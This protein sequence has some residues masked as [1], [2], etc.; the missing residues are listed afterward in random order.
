MC[1]RTLNS[2]KLLCVRCNLDNGL[3]HAHYNMNDVIFCMFLIWYVLSF[4]VY[5]LS[6]QMHAFYGIKNHVQHF[7]FSFCYFS[8]L[9]SQDFSYVKMCCKILLAI[10]LTF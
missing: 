2:L 6:N 1:A 8:Y 9:S 3:S 10:L 4:L 5:V 7:M